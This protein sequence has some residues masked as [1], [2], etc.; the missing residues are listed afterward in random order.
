MSKESKLH[1]ASGDAALISSRR[2]VRARSATHWQGLPFATPVVPAQRAGIAG[3]KLGGVVPGGADH[4]PHVPAGCSKA[5]WA[6]ARLVMSAPWADAHQV[7]RAQPGA[8]GLRLLDL[9]VAADSLAAGGLGAGSPP[10]G[11][12]RPPPLGGAEQ[13]VAG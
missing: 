3:L 8:A 11:G 5:R 6:A 1:S 4:I 12:G 10:A 2:R 9:R 7:G 13:F